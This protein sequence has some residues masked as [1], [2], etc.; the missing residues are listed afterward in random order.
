[1]K[2]ST[3]FLLKDTAQFIKECEEDFAGVSSDDYYEA[4]KSFKATALDLIQIGENINALLKKDDTPLNDQQ[5]VPWRA[6][7][8]F[9]N[10]VVHDYGGLDEDEV[11]EIV[12]KNLPTLKTVIEE[13]VRN[14]KNS[15]D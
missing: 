2:K 4:R 5:G 15:G 6:I 11:I 14:N 12:Q 3:Y 1:M 7:V 10:I 9:R 8:N 13:L